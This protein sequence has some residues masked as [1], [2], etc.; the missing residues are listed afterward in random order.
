MLLD[1]QRNTFEVVEYLVPHRIKSVQGKFR[2]PKPREIAL[3]RIK[4]RHDRH[5]S[6]VEKNQPGFRLAI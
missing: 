2:I 1:I 5:Q 4:A 6:L 3:I